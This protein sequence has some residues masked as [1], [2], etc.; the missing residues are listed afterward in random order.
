MPTHTVTR[1]DASAPFYDA[2]ARGELLLRRCADCPAWAAPRTLTCPSC[3]GDRLNWQVASGSAALVSWTVVHG[4]PAADGGEVPQAIAALVESAE[5]P[6]LHGR[7]VGAEPASLA[8]GLPLSLAFERPGDG[9]AV[10]VFRPV[11]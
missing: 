4:R 3:G 2:T 8:A 5:G 7:L 11:D 9:E 6:W 1:D 10:P